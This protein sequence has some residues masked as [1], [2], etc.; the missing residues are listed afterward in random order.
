[1]RRAIAAA[2]IAVVALTGACAPGGPSGRSVVAQQAQMSQTLVAKLREKGKLIE[3]RAL[4]AYV[5]GIVRRIEA[6]R[7]RGSVPIRVHIVKDADV[8]AFTPGGGHV[9]VNAGMIAAL[10]NEAQLAMVL[11]HEIAHIDRGHVE[12]GQKTGAA[13]S[14]AT[15]GAAVLA[16]T[17]GVPGDVTQLAAGGIQTTATNYYSRTQESDADKVGFRYAAAAGYNVAEG[18]KS[19]A[20]LRRIYGEESDIANF[21][22]SSHPQSAERQAELTRLARQA[23]ADKGRVA[24]AEYLRRTAELRRQVLRYYEAKGRKKEA[25]QLRR[26]LRRMR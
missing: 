15:V 22:M 5:G 24:A 17:L 3:D 2:L 25:A 12:A 13:I 11:A 26:N 23:G 4:N 10:E 7:P 1:M 16:G 8:N 21:F 19:F 20:V 18:A 6:V 14:L 9:F